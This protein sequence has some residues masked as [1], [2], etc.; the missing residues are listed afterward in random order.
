[1]AGGFA[2]PAAQKIPRAQAQVFGCKEPDTEKVAGDLVTQELPDLPFDAPFITGLNA[3]C[4]L[5]PLAFDA[6]GVGRGKRKME[7][8]FGAR[9]R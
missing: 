9:I 6:W 7:F 2:G 3:T 4:G 1:M 5:C 8:F